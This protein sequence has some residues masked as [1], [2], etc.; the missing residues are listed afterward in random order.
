MHDFRLDQESKLGELGARKV[1]SKLKVNKSARRYNNRNRLLPGTEYEY[2]GK[3]YIMR[4]Q[5]TNG[6]YYMAVGSDE[7][8]PAKKCKI[9]HNNRGLVF[10]MQS[11]VT[12]A[13]K[14]LS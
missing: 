2:E 7:K 12:K 4:S 13:H 9:L 5:I 3:R 10:V 11:Q 8:M 14:A 1:I 6:Y